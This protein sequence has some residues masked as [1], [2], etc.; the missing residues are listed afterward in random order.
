M[1][2]TRARALVVDGGPRHFSELV[3]DFRKEAFGRT[4]P[5]AVLAKRPP[6][7]I[8]FHDVIPIDPFA[9]GAAALSVV[10]GD[11]NFSGSFTTL[12]LAQAVCPPPDRSHAACFDLFAGSIAG[13]LERASPFSSLLRRRRRR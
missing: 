6:I 8:E 11:L 4:Q 2:T 12:F 7:S 13:E 10:R 9:R 5:D 3:H 1:S